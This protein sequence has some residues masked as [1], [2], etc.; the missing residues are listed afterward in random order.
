MLPDPTPSPAGW[1]PQ[2]IFSVFK[3]P[4][5]C[6]EYANTEVAENGIVGVVAGL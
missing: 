6:S 4:Q 5:H 1:L 3:S 2:L